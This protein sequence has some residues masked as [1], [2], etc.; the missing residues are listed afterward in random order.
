MASTIDNRSSVHSAPPTVTE[1]AGAAK[2]VS[3]LPA[4]G[5]ISG[6]Q[7]RDAIKQATQDLD[8]QA[9]GLEYNQLK[10]WASANKDRLSPEAQKLFQIYDRYALDALK[11]GK[12]GIDTGNYDKMLKEMDGALPPTWQK[13]DKIEGSWH[14]ASNLQQNVFGEIKDAYKDFKEL[15]NRQ[16]TYNDSGAGKAL[17]DLDNKTTLDSIRNA[18]LSGS[19]RQ[20][21]V[22]GTDMV[23]TIDKATSDLD[24]QA[25]GLEYRD[26]KTWQDANKNNLSPEAKKVLDIYDKYATKALG[27]G[28]THLTQDEHKSMIAEMREA[29]KPQQ[30]ATEYND[31]SAGKAIETLNDK[32]RG[33]GQGDISGKDMTNA[34]N[35]GTKDGDGQAAGLEYRDFKTWFNENKDKLSPEAKKVME[36]YDRYATKVMGDGRTSFTAAEHKAMIA[37]MRQAEKPAAQHLDAGAGKAIDG[38]NEKLGQKSGSKIDGQ[39]LTQAILKGTEDLD[40]QAAGLEY[41]E[42]RKWANENAASLSPEAKKVMEIYDKYVTEAHKQGR[43]GILPEDHAKMVTEMQDASKP[44]LT[45]TDVMNAYSFED[46]RARLPHKG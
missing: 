44:K 18:G 45:A 41:D 13:M 16:P 38:L 11:Q 34:I 30:K 12:T 31:K 4:Q 15:L 25:A 14:Q 19:G 24:G 27:E 6:E 32:L 29:A 36:I 46:I 39:E 8:G 40:N 21:S 17:R 37:E 10:D 35:R 26:V 3:S 20:A 23:D 42:F 33:P 22:S 43:T 9:A 2:S 7:A 28:R 5:P 1:D